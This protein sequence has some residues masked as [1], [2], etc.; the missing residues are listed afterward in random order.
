MDATKFKNAFLYVDLRQSDSAFVKCTFCSK[1]IIIRII[2]NE[3][4]FAV[5]G[6]PIGRSV[7][8]GRGGDSPQPDTQKGSFDPPRIL[9]DRSR[10]PLVP[11]LRGLSPLMS[12]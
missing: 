5:S 3:N 9:I 2:P 10:P 1:I 7:Q 8:V 11:P 12:K 4:S 6:T